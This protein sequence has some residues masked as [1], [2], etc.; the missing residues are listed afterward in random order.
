MADGGGVGLQDAS[1]V[2]SG[3]DGAVSPENPEEKQQSIWEAVDELVSVDRSTLVKIISV[4]LSVLLGVSIWLIHGE[5]SRGRSDLA[6]VYG[7]F[8]FLV[9]GLIGSIAFVVAEACRLEGDNS[10]AASVTEKKEN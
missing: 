6:L 2:G 9:L 1:P 4:V 3:G 5:V 8:L 7:V 10:A